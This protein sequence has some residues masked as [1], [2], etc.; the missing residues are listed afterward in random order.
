[1]AENVSS[2]SHFHTEDTAVKGNRRKDE[3][4]R[5]AWLTVLGSFLVYYSSFGIINSFGF[6]QNYYQ[7][8]YLLNA[9]PAQISIIGTLQMA[10]MNVLS[11]VSGGICDEHGIRVSK[12][13]FTRY[14]LLTRR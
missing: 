10:L 6:F 1:M 14:L 7:T 13:S 8:E 5:E 3:G 2:I 11:T 9:S 4:G 12:S